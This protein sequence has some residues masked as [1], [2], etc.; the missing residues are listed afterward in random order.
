MPRWSKVDRCIWGDA[1]FRALSSAQ[2]NGQTLFLRL[3]IAPELGPIPGLFSAWE[4]GLAQA[5]GWDLKPFRERFAELLRE[6]LAKADWE[7]GLVYVPKAIKHNA[8]SNPNIV[9]GWAETWRL[10]PECALKDEAYHGL[11]L[12]VEPL[13]KGF[14]E[15]FRVALGNRSGNHCPNIE[16]ER[17]IEREINKDPTDPLSTPSG[18]DSPPTKKQTKEAA[19]AEQAKTIWEFFCE[20]RAAA[21]P[22]LGKLTPTKARMSNIKAR[23]KEHEPKEVCRVIKKFVDPRF[24]WGANGKL[25][26]E[27]LF[28]SA[29]KFEQVRD[30][31]PVDGGD[32]GKA[33]AVI[34]DVPIV[35][36][37]PRRL[38]PRP[39]GGFT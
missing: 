21:D 13:G 26:F 39:P 33:R 20:K 4:A 12:F 36:T 38:P 23:L 18:A 15:S 1:K 29:H 16:I 6:G 32:N 25:D 34:Q 2:P 17:E 19:L 31:K 9:K 24:W 10:M 35:F 7:A 27:L 5:L 14:A 28:R 3:L 11:K 8:P 22:S 30:A 37:S